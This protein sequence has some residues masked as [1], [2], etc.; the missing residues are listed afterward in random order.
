M[1]KHAFTMALIAPNNAPSINGLVESPTTT[2]P[3]QMIHDA[4]P[5]VLIGT[6]SC[7]T[8][9]RKCSL[10]Q[11]MPLTGNAL[12]LPPPAFFVSMLSRKRGAQHCPRHACHHVPVNPEWPA[13]GLPLC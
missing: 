9:Y 7:N 11:P 10:V 8:H 13:V 3:A 1:H 6:T 5:C 2:V 12:S 4:R